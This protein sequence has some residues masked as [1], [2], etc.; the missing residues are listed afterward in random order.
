[1]TKKSDNQHRYGIILPGA[2]KH[3][4]GNYPEFRYI[5]KQLRRLGVNWFEREIYGKSTIFWFFESELPKL[6]IDPEGRMP[7]YVPKDEEDQCGHGISNL[8]EFL[9]ANSGKD[10]THISQP[11]TN[12]SPLR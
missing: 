12:Q 3:R 11:Q 10:T 5:R 6:P 4:G 8:D 1:M 7:Q 2:K 9:N